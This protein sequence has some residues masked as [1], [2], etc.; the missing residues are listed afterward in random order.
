LHGCSKFCMRKETSTGGMWEKKQL[1]I[2]WHPSLLMRENDIVSKIT[3]TSQDVSE[4][5]SKRG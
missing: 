1:R 2:M 5:G 3:E 4:E